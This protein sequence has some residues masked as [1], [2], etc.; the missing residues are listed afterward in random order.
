MK[1]LFI[2]ALMG[3]VFACPLAGQ[4]WH[5]VQKNDTLWSISRRYGVPLDTLKAQNGIAGDQIRIGQR[6]KLPA[7]PAA[8]APAASVAPAAK[9]AA[10]AAQT[11]TQEARHVV[12]AGETLW[13]ISRR[14]GVSVDALKQ[15]NGL[16]SDSIHSGQ[17]LR[18]RGTQAAAQN[19]PVKSAPVR[20]PPVKSAPARPQSAPAFSWPVK[21]PVVEK[22]GIP[23]KGIINAITIGAKQETEVRS[24]AAGTVTYA[25]PFRGYGQ[26]VIIRHDNLYYSV[27]ANLSQIQVQKGRAV[28]AR[29][30]IGR[31]GFIAG[32]GSHGVHFQLYKGENAKEKAVNP[33]A[34]LAG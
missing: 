22:F 4:E 18:V 23:Q 33:L 5:T 24:A 13:R 31:T 3:G 34:Y 26:V 20:P 29:E 12:Q 21:G 32:A 2:A 8:K 28:A 7:A 9:A 15:D 17:V 16:K 27:Y 19:Q 10:P 30:A 6:L 11:R 1:A 14:Y 25:G